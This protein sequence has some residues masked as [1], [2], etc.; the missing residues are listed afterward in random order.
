MNND[1]QMHMLKEGTLSGLPI[2]YGIKATA[3]INHNMGMNIKTFT[4]KKWLHMY[5]LSADEQR[6]VDLSMEEDR[7]L[8]ESEETRMEILNIK[9]KP[10]NGSVYVKFYSTSGRK[11]RWSAM[12]MGLYGAQLLF[13]ERNQKDKEIEMLAGVSKRR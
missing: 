12:C 6:K 13:K 4:Q 9:N 1:E 7:L 5:P 11:D 2:I 10:I 3:E 8:F